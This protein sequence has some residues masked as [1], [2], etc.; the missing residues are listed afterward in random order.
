M[1]TNMYFPSMLRAFDFQGCEDKVQC[2][3]MPVCP[4]C[5]GLHTL[6]RPRFFAGQLLTEEDLNR[7]DRYMVEK[8]RLHNRYIHGWGVVC[9]LEVVCS[10]CD[11]EGDRGKVVVK[12]GYALSPCGNDIVVSRT[13]TVDVCD[14]VNRCR[15]PVDEC[16]SPDTENNCEDAEEEWIIAVCYKEHTA[17]EVVALRAASGCSEGKQAAGCNCQT[18]TP[19]TKQAVANGVNVTRAPQCEPTVV[20]ETYGFRAYR[21]PKLSDRKQREMG[22]LVKR[23][24]CCIVPFL[25]DLGGLP[26]KGSTAAQRHQ[27][28]LN[29][30]E[31]LREFLR[32]EGLYDCEVAQKLGGIE[33]PDVTNTHYL[34]A[35]TNATVG[36][37]S[38]A[39][40]VLQKCLCSALLPP[41]PEPAMD[42]CVPIAT[43][44]LRRNPCRVVKVCNVSSRRFLLTWP[45]VHYWLS[46]MPLF[47]PVTGKKPARTLRDKLMQLCCTVLG[48][49]FQ[50]QATGSIDAL[51]RMEEPVYKAK[52]FGA[53]DTSAAQKTDG[54]FASLLASALSEHEAGADLGTLLLAAMG[55]PD[56]NGQPLASELE[57]GNPA[58][59]MLMNQLLAPMLKSMLPMPLLGG[60]GGAG[61]AASADE[62]AEMR[63][64]LAALSKVVKTQAT[65]INQLKKRNK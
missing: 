34:K 56:A 63:K 32:R 31:A 17:R 58:E 50:T 53:K 64:E 8:N 3:P 21:A 35:W 18:T 9:G 15:P 38:V 48:E 22:A 33:S 25:E 42:D 5:G 60:A 7:L 16:F 6:C 55:A 45:N 44:T 11:R 43:V 23:F 13:E 59:F 10:V 27:W 65:T 46:W 39:L 4:T 19:G 40:L 51:H 28:L 36:V 30:K 49:R 47:G 37:L 52:M 41:C 24:V 20:C 61:A 14:L 62:V 29:L 2:D 57:L 54:V 26:A 12:P 1:A